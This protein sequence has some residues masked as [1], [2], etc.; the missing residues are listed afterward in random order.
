MSNLLSREGTTYLELEALLDGRYRVVQILSTEDWGQ[1]YLAQDTRRPSQPQCIIQHVRPIAVEPE[2]QDAIRHLFVREAAILEKLADHDQIPQLLACFEDEEG[3]YLVQ[4][5]VSGYPLSLELQTDRF[6]DENEVVQLLLECLEPLSFVHN[7]GIRHGNLTPENLVRRMHDGKF[8]LVGFDSI[9]QLHLSLLSLHGY[10]IAPAEIINQGYQAPE[11]LQGMPCLASDVYSIGVIAIHAL[12]GTH[13]SLFQTGSTQGEFSWQTSLQK[14]ELHPREEFIALL[15]RMVHPDCNQRY[16]SAREALEAVQ[17]FAQSVVPESLGDASLTVAV[18]PGSV[19]Y[20]VAQSPLSSQKLSPAERQGMALMV[21]LGIGTVVTATSVGYAFLMSPPDLTDRGPQVLEQAK[22]QYQSGKLPQA[23][24]LAESIPIT[25]QAYTSARDAIDAWQQDWREAT[26]VYQKMQA[27]LKQSNWQAVLQEAKALPQNAYW[28]E[29]TADLV[30]QANRIAEDKATQLM[31]KAYGDA[32]AKNFTRALDTLKQ[33][34][35]GTTVYS[36]AQE[37]IREYAQKR[38]IRA[39][40]LLQEAYNRAMKRDFEGAL[41]YLRQIS[42][43]TSAYATA[44]NKIQEYTRKQ[45]IRLRAWLETAER[46]AN[47]SSYLSALAS[48]EKIPAGSSIDAKVEEKTAEYTDRLSV[49]SDDL[50]QKASQQATKQDYSSALELLKQ[51]P[52]GTPAYSEAREKMG[53]YARLQQ[54]KQAGVLQPVETEAIASKRDSFSDRL[55][56]TPAPSSTLT[57]PISHIQDLNPGSY[58]REVSP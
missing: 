12:T 34:P 57:V 29:R 9:R 8:V 27:A 47:A 6:W 23:I 25:S 2:Y 42:P 20:P 44:K 19:L 15:N 56:L 51:I 41:V 24:S 21:G 18:E 50:L 22:T 30:Q 33:I 36:Q 39:T 28:K 45:E 38:E 43:E 3:F 1:V 54:Q 5:F 17:E 26:A 10:G 46:Q 14:A 16:A 11:Q 58:L 55:S 49:W 32:I 37:K 40:A 13:P 52:L 35:E 48:L 7:Q 31:V 4:E 53:E